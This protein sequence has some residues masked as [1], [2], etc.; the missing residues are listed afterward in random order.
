MDGWMDGWIREYSL[1]R[2]Q[3]KALTR[4]EMMPNSEDDERGSYLVER[5]Q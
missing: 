2:L 5:Q 1:E 3:G 4:L